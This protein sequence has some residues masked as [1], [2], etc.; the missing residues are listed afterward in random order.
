HDPIT[1]EKIRAG[2]QVV[3]C[4]TCK[5]AFLKESWEYLGKKHCGQFLTLRTFPKS[6][7]VKIERNLGRRFYQAR[8]NKFVPWYAVRRD[9]RESSETVFARIVALSAGG[10]L[11]VVFSKGI[12][13]IPI[14]LFVLVNQFWGALGNLFFYEPL[15]VAFFER[16]LRLFSKKDKAFKVFYYTQLKSIELEQYNYVQGARFRLNYGTGE[17]SQWLIPFRQSKGLHELL[18]R[19]SSQV[20]TTIRVGDRNEFYALKRLQSRY[21]SLNIERI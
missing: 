21:P 13:I 2:Q 9:A 16:G 19:A 10:S 14:L 18:A 7:V 8:E 6:A 4:A 12:L 1:G 3:F 15:E 5:S 20:T 17:T 11:V